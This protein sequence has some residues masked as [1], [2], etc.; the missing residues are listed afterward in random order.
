MYAWIWRHL[1]G[2]WQAKSGIAAAV[3]IVVALVLWYVV[4]PW[5]EPK[6]HF[7]H[8]VVHGEPTGSSGPA[9]PGG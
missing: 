2:T 4:F 7:D 3:A 8:G 1:P 5:M 9:V 6:V